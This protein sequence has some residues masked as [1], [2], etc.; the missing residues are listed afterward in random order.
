MADGP[1]IP[2]V[3]PTAEPSVREPWWK[4]AVFYQIYP[5]SFADSDRDGIGDLEGIRTHLADLVWLG[6]DALWLSPFFPSP[7]VDFGYDVR[8]Y[9]GVD[10]LFGTLAGFDRLVEEAH[11]LGLKVM[12]DWVPN[13]TSDQHPWF[14]DARS[15]TTSSHRDW[16]VWRDATPDGLPPNNWVAS[17][18]LS[19]PAW[20]LDATSDQWY[21][22]LFDAA[23]PDLNWDH[24]AVAEALHDVL[25]FWLDRGRR[26]GPTSST[27]SARTPS[28]PTTRRSWPAFPTAPSTTSRSPTMG[29]GPSADSS[30]STP[31]TGSSWARSS[32]CR[33][34]RWP[35]TTAMATSSISLQLPTAVRPLA[36]G[37]LD[38][39]ASSDRPRSGPTRRLAHLGPVQP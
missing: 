38:P 13:H 29:S 28:C 5:R 21:L 25:R 16:Y 31:A 34:R 1:P 9:C 11:R 17:F 8:D 12:I 32:S 4:S 7:M 27:A 20:T 19:A 3:S 37:R 36:A 39:G 14:A 26:S 6:V 23:Q 30:T 22:H 15:G 18:D 2:A 33:P 24:P 35:P 10:P